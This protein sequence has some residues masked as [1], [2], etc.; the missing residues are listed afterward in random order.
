MMVFIEFMFDWIF[1][2]HHRSLSRVFTI[3]RQ[4]YKICF[5]CGAKLRYSWRTMSLIKT[6]SQQMPGSFALVWRARG[7]HA[8]N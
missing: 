3:D 4:T 1:C 8:S 6:E 2:C 5:S 7:R